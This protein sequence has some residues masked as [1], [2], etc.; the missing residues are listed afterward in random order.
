[1]ARCAKRQ[2]RI[3]LNRYKIE[4]QQKQAQA[5]EGLKTRVIAVLTRT[6][7][8]TRQTQEDGAEENE[9]K[10]PQT[11]FMIMHFYIQMLSINNADKQMHTLK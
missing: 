4:K 3:P 9:R 7:Y 2:K 8:I 10:H 6:G 5:E 11:Y 1:M